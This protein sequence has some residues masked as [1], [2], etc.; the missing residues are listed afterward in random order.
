MVQLLIEIEYQALT[1]LLQ[2]QESRP[3]DTDDSEPGY[4]RKGLD[5]GVTEVTV[6]C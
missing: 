1:S 4:S 3:C 5:G 2:T 6:D